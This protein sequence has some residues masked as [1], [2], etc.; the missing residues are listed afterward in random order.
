MMTVEVRSLPPTLAAV[1]A[2]LEL[3]EASYVTLGQIREIAQRYGISSHAGDLAWRLRRNGWLL[4]TP[5]RGV[6]EFAPAAHGG[7]YGRGDVFAVLR[8]ELD[9]RP[10]EDIRVGLVSALWLR[11]WA[12][13]PPSRHELT[14]A[15]DAPVSTGLG[16]V[17][18]ILRFG[19]HST[20]DRLRGLPVESIAST[21]VHAAARPAHVSGWEAV[22]QALPD[23]VA[24]TSPE[25]LREEVSG[26][27]SAVAARLGYLLQGVAPDLVREAGLQP[28]AGTTRFGPRSGE[29]LRFDSD[30]NVVD[31]ILPFDPAAVA[32]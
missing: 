5:R 12:E 16:R 1:V 15:A 27:P 4:P 11:G 22:E 20:P 3:D 14:T 25:Q 9:L 7:R 23:L 10:D 17:Y 31:T 29:T 19:S 26:R 6:W 2:D 28:G 21:L 32:G 13:R 18:R 8:G 24:A 30:W